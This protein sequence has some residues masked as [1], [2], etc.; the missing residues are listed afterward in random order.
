MKTT[1]SSVDIYEEAI[2]PM[3]LRHDPD[4][5]LD[6]M[7]VLRCFFCRTFK[8]PIEFDMRIHLSEIHQEELATDLPLKG[9][10]FDMSYL[11]GFAID[12]MMHE[13]PKE[14]YDHKT[15]RFGPMTFD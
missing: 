6:G 2:F 13:T 9:K 10:G 8:T 12:I 1:D 14:F 15:A 11:V 3:N 5:V 7:L 4:H